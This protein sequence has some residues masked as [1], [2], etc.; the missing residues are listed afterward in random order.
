MDNLIAVSSWSLHRTLGVSYPDSPST[1]LGA[2]QKHSSSPLPLH[3]LPAAL[4]AHGYTAMQLC[5]FHLPSR[6][7]CYIADFR[8]ALRSAQVELLTLLIDEGDVSDPVHGE[9]SVGWTS[10]WVRSAADLGASRAR[11]IAGKQP[12][13][14]E[15][16]DLAFSR[17]MEIAKVAEEVGVQLEIENW[18][19]LLATPDAVNE[20]LDRSE[21]ALR[22][23]ADF[24]N[25][26]KPERYE[27]LP[28]IM[29]RAE[30]CHSKFEFVSPTELDLDD[31]TRCLAIA[32]EA[33]FAGPMV[34]VNG[35][36]GESDWD[37]MEIQRAAIQRA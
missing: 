29:G 22:L 10:S 5:H 6:D 15:A 24:G 7:I 12:Y 17:L 28:K 16:L 3:D 26:P 32:K 37:A 34:L 9:D 13:S 27:T 33:N 23:N 36:I 8:S 4:Q 35:G 20:L 19:A 11:I 21:G 18:H 31:T 14:R 2:V 25:W 1:G 30:T